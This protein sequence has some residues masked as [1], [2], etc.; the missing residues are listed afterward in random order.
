ME[1][2]YTVVFNTT[3]NGAQQVA[4]IVAA[5][6]SVAPAAKEA[7]RAVEGLGQ[8]AAAAAGPIRE[9]T[10]SLVGMRAAMFAIQEVKQVLG[11][12]AEGYAEARKYAEELAETNI[13]LRDTLRELQYVR[14]DKAGGDETPMAV[15]D[16][17]TKTG[18]R[19]GEADKFLKGGAFMEANIP[20]DR[21][22]AQ[23]VLDAISLEAARATVRGNMDA[24]MTAKIASSIPLYNRIKDAD[25]GKEVFAR[26]TNQ[27]SKRGV[28]EFAKLGPS[29][30]SVLPDFAG[31][32]ARKVSSED[33]A[34]MYAG[35]TAKFST[36]A[37]AAT[38]LKQM[39]RLTRRLDGKEGG[40]LK[41]MGVTEDMSPLDAL[42][43]IAPHVQGDKGDRFLAQGGFGNQTE[44]FAA[45]KFA[46]ALP[47]IEEGLAA[48]R[49]PGQAAALEKADMDALTKDP[50][51]QARVADAH[52][53]RA[54]FRRG[55][56]GEPL[57]V[58]KRA[59]LA[60]LNDP[61]RPG[62]PGIDTPLTSAT[63]FLARIGG[64]GAV[65]PRN[66]RLEDEAV[67][68]LHRQGRKVGVDLGA[69]FPG[70]FSGRDGEGGFSRFVAED[71]RP[72]IFGRAVEAVRAAGGDPYGINPEGGGGAGNAKALLKQAASTLNNAANAL[73]SGRPAGGPPARASAPGGPSSVPPVSPARP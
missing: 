2:T 68:E 40:A 22:P 37:R 45:V 27:L 26:I 20:A 54:K 56:A 73:P 16:L 23:G 31:E 5:M 13:K 43:A 15:L 17:M 19:A 29:F 30:F 70:T 42:R 8:G 10:A 71:Q 21:K 32:G 58:A 55:L 44:I 69:A 7:E 49:V 24:G 47:A 57:Q 59:A 62:G 14:G 6:K 1:R 51:I 4:A 65:D 34:A 25:E 33:L 35:G 9:T 18:M 39:V 52:A 53:E 28:G 63:D 48:N 60:R 11:A 67:A 61:D 64:A 46:Q 72:A 38:G 41:A 50:A 3:G 66:A 12:L 36:P